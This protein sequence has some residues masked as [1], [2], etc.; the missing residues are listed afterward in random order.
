[1]AARPQVHHDE[2][3]PRSHKGERKTDERLSFVSVDAGGEKGDRDHL[4]NS[5]N[6]LAE[7]VGV[8]A[9]GIERETDPR[10]PDGNKQSGEHRGSTN[11]GVFE[12]SGAQTG[13]R[14]N[15]HQVVEELGPGDLALF[16]GV[17]SAQVR[18]S[19]SGDLHR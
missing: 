7:I 5:E 14:H 16:C 3:G 10:P 9:I 12:E 1:M 17:C 18:R 11:G 4:G 6:P 15:K 8:V 19:D 2:N 13:D